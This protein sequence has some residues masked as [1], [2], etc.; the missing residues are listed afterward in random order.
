MYYMMIPVYLK[1]FLGITWRADETVQQRELRRT[2]GF[3]QP[4]DRAYGPSRFPSDIQTSEAGN[5]PW[6]PRHDEYD[7]GDPAMTK[8]WMRS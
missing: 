3:V 5:P 4:F 6:L 1:F 8:L 2:Q 7:A